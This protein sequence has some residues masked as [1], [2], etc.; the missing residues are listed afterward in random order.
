MAT[1]VLSLSECF[2]GLLV[3]IGTFQHPPWLWKG[4]RGPR[5]LKTQRP[6]TNLPFLDF[7]PA[8]T[9]FRCIWP[10]TTAARKCRGRLNYDD[11]NWANT[12]RN[13]IADDTPYS[14]RVPK[15][16]REYAE[17]CLCHVHRPHTDKTILDDW[18]HQWLS[19]IRTL[20]DAQCNE[21]SKENWALAGSLPLYPLTQVIETR[22]EENQGQDLEGICPSFK[23]ETSAD[24]TPIKTERSYYMPGGFP[25]GSLLNET[26]GSLVGNEPAIEFEC[27][28]L[29]R[30]RTPKKYS[31]TI[32]E[33][34][35][36]LARMSFTRKTSA[37]A[38]LGSF[39]ARSNGKAVAE[40]FEPYPIDAR[41]S[42]LSVLNRPLGK[43][44]SKSGQIYI[45]SRPSPDETHRH[46]VKI[47]VAEDVTGRLK[48]WQ[49][50][51]HYE[52]HLEHETV[53]I[54]NA[55]RVELLVH[56][57]FIRKR[58]IERLCSGCG[59]N[60]DE[61]I[62]IDAATAISVVNRWAKWMQDCQ[63]YTPDGQLSSR[64]VKEIFEHDMSKV[65]LTGRKMLALA[66]ET[67]VMESTQRS[68]LDNT[69]F[70]RTLPSNHGPNFERIDFPQSIV[71]TANEAL[72]KALTDS[73][74]NILTK[75]RFSRKRLQ[76][77]SHTDEGDAS[78]K[79]LRYLDEVKVKLEPEDDLNDPFV[80]DVEASDSQESYYDAKSLPEHS[81]C[82]VKAKSELDASSTCQQ[83]ITS[84]SSER[85]RLR[86]C[87]P[88][89]LDRGVYSMVGTTS[90]PL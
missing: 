73:D 11:R 27:P 24:M 52:P 10:D 32:L 45:F 38:R 71:D 44:E 5:R 30:N 15:M 49:N 56:T 25:G 17:Y 42:L 58:R 35:L 3:M 54:P 72:A 14:E 48:E 12:L 60:H 40:I 46:Y 89:K 75:R 37:P 68:L 43:N 33:S 80:S 18:V 50:R 23:R 87:G 47:G 21:L 64:V 34:P 85:L 90:S 83:L 74:N 59:G 36:G 63:P 78:V 82:A 7:S 51:C 76:S 9:S 70:R 69:Y 6:R 22:H 79:K 41:Q 88:D 4:H 1:F 84:W 55:M 62:M 19:E 2:L 86:S 26:N 28:P 29:P 31:Q 13:T 61:W 39:L 8:A 53:L 65:P 20:F 57:E 16:L 81:L 66:A 77:F 67:D